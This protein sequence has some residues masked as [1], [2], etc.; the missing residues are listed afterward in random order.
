MTWH[1]AALLVVSFWGSKLEGATGIVTEEVASSNSW[2]LAIQ[3]GAVF[4]L[5]STQ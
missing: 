5:N 3:T 2:A 4:G 1:G